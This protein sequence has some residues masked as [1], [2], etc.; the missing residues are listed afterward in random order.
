MKKKI[1]HILLGREKQISA[2]E[3]VKQPLP[4]KDFR[5]AN[6]IIVLH[7]KNGYIQT[8]TEVSVPIP[9]CCRAKDFIATMPA[10]IIS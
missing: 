1:H 8:R 10:M 2:E 7:Q 5:F 4:H 9:L 6:P 3:V